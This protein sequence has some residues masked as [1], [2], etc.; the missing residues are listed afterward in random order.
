[1]AEMD[2]ATFRTHAVEYFEKGDYDRAI[3]DASEAIRLNPND[4]FAYGTRGAA[5]KGKKDFDHA[6]A[7]LTEAIRLDPNNAPAYGNRG[8]AY[9]NKE[10][11]DHAIGDLEMAVKLQPDNS[12]ARQALEKIK[13]ARNG[14][15]S[16]DGSLSSRII[17]RI[18][19]IPIIGFISGFIFRFIGV[20]F[21]LI[22]SN[23]IIEALLHV[24]IIGALIGIII[25]AL[26]GIIT[27][28]IVGLAF[29]FK[30]PIIFIIL[31]II[32]IIL[33]IIIGIISIINGAIIGFNYSRD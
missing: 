25:G 22:S 28:P 12:G 2:A 6:I 8:L 23:H 29:I 31:A 3:A 7:D 33:W 13:A 17:D 15:G 27:S 32:V 19:A 5:Y 11:Y 24:P 30:N 16:S 20:I 9:L 26:I 1:M 21:D 10:D 14:S 4:A 18:E